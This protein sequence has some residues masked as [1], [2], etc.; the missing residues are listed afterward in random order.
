M[1]AFRHVLV[2][3]DFSD[4]SSE[5]IDVA[6]ELAR[7]Y[8]AALTLLHVY[9]VPSYAY[10]EMVYAPIDFVTP[11]R[12]AA[13]KSLKSAHA[14]LAQR[15][16]GA[17]SVLRAGA[18]WEQIVGAVQEL[19]ADLVVVGTHGRRGLSHALLG[20]VAERVV[21]RSLVPVLTVRRH[22]PTER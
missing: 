5:A 18:A 4:C 14:E 8:D 9:E 7:R 22:S 1:G 6:I 10:G 11:I 13:E 20:S 12:E 3:T 21:Q 19:K 17:K 2:A 15:F 16:P